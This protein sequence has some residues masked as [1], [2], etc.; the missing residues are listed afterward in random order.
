MVTSVQVHVRKFRE[1]LPRAWAY[2]IKLLL[3]P[4]CVSFDLCPFMSPSV[5]VCGDPLFAPLSTSARVQRRV[6]FAWS[7]VMV[8]AVITREKFQP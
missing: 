4:L 8:C 6:E 1:R 5:G 7:V 3:L 2:L